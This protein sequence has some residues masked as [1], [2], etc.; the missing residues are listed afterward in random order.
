MNKKICIKHE[1]M[2]DNEEGNGDTG[3]WMTTE[4][5]NSVEQLEDKVGETSYKVE[6]KRERD[7]K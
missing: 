7:E 4:I 6:Q 1:R 5:K 3:K 2:I